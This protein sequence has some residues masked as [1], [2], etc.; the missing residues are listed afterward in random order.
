MA[1]RPPSLRSIAA[2]EA[3]ARLGSFAKAAQELHLTQSAIS[4]S[5]RA[6]EERIG[7]ALIDRSKTT[8]TLTPTG[9]TLASRVRVSL[10]LLNEAFQMESTA[11]RSTLVVSALGSVAERLLV[12]RLPSFFSAHA[13]IEI[14]LHATRRL[15]DLKNGEADIA[16]R[17]GPG[18]WPG[19]SAAL[20]ARDTV[21]PVASPHYRGGHL[22]QALSDLSECDIIVHPAISWQLWLEAADA[23]NN[24]KRGQLTTDDAALMIQAAIA[25]CGVALVN[26]KLVREDLAAGRL[27]KLFGT[28][29]SDD[30][31]HWVV[32][33]NSSPKLA[34][35]LRFVE[36]ARGEFATLDLPGP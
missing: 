19:L 9:A 3:V 17:F 11:A 8:A 30:Y 29:A 15:A 13:D 21:F 23:P 24:L 36:W 33:D 26:E 10:S 28:E 20:L 31:A 32:W 5:V 12:P 6:L 7:E 27:V 14:H 4:H 25:G 2:F 1:I 18:H 35:I 22:P 34:T 16:I